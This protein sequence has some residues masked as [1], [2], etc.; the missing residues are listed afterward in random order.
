MDHISL[1][2]ISYRSLVKL[3]YGEFGEHEVNILN[4]A[5]VLKPFLNNIVAMRG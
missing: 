1:S 4:S 5:M 2:S 3:R